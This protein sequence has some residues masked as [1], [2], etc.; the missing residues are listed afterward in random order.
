[1]T[2]TGNQPTG[3]LGVALSGT[4]A[5]SFALSGT[6]IPSI[7]AGGSATFTVG[8]NHGLS[9]GEYIATV[10]V[11][12][13][14]ITAQS[15]TVTFEV[16]DPNLP[17]LSAPTGLAVAD[18]ALT[19]NLVEGAGGYR[20]YAGD[21]PIGTTVGAA[22][23]SFNLANAYPA[24]TPGE[25]YQLR[26]RALGVYGA[27]NNSEKSAPV[28]FTV[29]Q[30]DGPDISLNVT[31]THEFPA[32]YQGYEPVTALTVTVSN[33]GDQPTGDLEVELSGINASSFTLSTD[34]IPSIAVGYSA[35]F[36]VGPTPV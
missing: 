4:N 14:D 29:A 1:M 3:N 30:Y 24:F 7:P 20:V 15:F 23:T 18:M 28:D 36:T 17:T 26:V 6:S 27:S 5:S 13:N 16:I 8:P 2:N 35:T 11:G 34:S 22:A 32:L 9:Q 12:G 21:V 33:I 31:D 25:T 19:W 10:T